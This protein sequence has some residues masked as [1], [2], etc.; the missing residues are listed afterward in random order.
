MLMLLTLK[1][2]LN[3]NLQVMFN[4][5]SLLYVVDVVL[6]KIFQEEKN[7]KWVQLANDLLYQFLCTRGSKSFRLK[8]MKGR[9]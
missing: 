7:E 8:L 4:T 5:K 6:H 9:V 1:W 2:I 3:C